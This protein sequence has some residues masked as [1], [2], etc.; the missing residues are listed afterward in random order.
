[1]DQLLITIEDI[2]QYRPMADITLARVD[3]YIREAQVNDL[4]EFLGAPLYYDLLVNGTTTENRDLL[5]GKVYTIPGSVPITIPFNGLVPIIV[6]HSL[7]RIVINN[8]ANI[9][10]F[11][12]VS[13]TTGQSQPIDSSTLKQMVTELRSIAVSYQN[14]AEKFLNANASSYPLWNYNTNTCEQSTGFQFF[15]L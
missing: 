2:K 10:S 13:K 6:Y 15:K 8:Q 4:K 5:N 9:T 11:G 7:A 1:M 12:V 14:E 3:S